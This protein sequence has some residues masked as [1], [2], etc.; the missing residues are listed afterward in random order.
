MSRPAASTD[1]YVDVPNIGTFSFAKRMLRDELRIAAEYSRLTEGVDTPSPWLN[2][3]AGW[4]AALTV[5][6][7]T[8]PDDWDVENMDPLD[9]E[10]YDKL[11]EVHVALRAKEDS[12]RPGKAKAGQAPGSGNS[13][14]AGVL[15]PA[16]VQPGTDGPA[17]P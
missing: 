8:A 5:L 2:I 7:V 9:Q 16:Q 15:V 4:I 12:F 11:R 10:T 17:V 13:E 14:V 1:F 6:T 3:V